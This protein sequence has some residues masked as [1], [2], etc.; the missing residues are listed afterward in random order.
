MTEM[1]PILRYTYFSAQQTFYN[2]YQQ[3]LI[4]IIDDSELE[5]L[6]TTRSFIQVRKHFCTPSWPC[7]HIS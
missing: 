5:V 7:L 4:N 3:A 6:S 1:W 2:L